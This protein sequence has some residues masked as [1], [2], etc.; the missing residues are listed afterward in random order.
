MSV[1]CSSKQTSCSSGKKDLLSVE[2]LKTT[3]IKKIIVVLSGKGG[4]G[5]SMVT[6]LLATSFAKKGYKVGVMDGDITGPSIPKILGMEGEC[7]G[8]E[9][10]IL[11]LESKLGIKAVSINFMLDDP[12]QPILWKG[13][14]IGSMVKQ[15]YSDVVWNELDYLFIDMPPGTGDVALTVFQSIPV[16]GVVVV[17]SPQDLVSMIVSKA[18]NMAKTMNK[19]IIGLVENMS[20]VKCPCC[21]EKIHIFNESKTLQT[22]QEF[23]VPFLAS[24][25]LDPKLAQAADAGK[26]EEMQV[27]GLEKLI[28]EVEHC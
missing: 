16:D 7:Y 9:E 3:K 4:V 25:P 5:K 1:N 21:N 18:L 2:A 24:L 6:A 20:Y 10:G 23:N 8:S 15:F 28:Y 19:P 27:E 14:I 17:T 11:P 26:L 13:P 22:A 12:G